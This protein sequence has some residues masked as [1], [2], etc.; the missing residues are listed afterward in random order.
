M[1][2]E[3]QTQLGLD[4]VQKRVK[5][6]KEIFKEIKGYYMFLMQVDLDGERKR[7][8]CSFWPTALPSHSL[9]LCHNSQQEQDN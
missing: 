3:L 6:Q 2:D 8:K 1:F 9:Q 7:V 5:Y 4:G